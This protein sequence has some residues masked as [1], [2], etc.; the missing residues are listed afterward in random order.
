MARP[1]SII[2]NGGRPVSN[3]ANLDADQGVPMTPVDPPL[4]G[5]PVTLVDA[6]A[7]GAAAISLVNEDGTIWTGG[8]VSANEEPL[9]A[10]GVSFPLKADGTSNPKKVA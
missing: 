10:D 5:E 2:S 7:G 6:G 1:V 8:D 4:Y 9:K 3:V